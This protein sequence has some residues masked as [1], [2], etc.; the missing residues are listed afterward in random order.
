M[1]L[2]QRNLLVVTELAVSGTQF[3]STS[4]LAQ[5]LFIVTFDKVHTQD[6]TYFQEHCCHKGNLFGNGCAA[7]HVAVLEL[8]WHMFYRFRQELELLHTTQEVAALI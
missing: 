8:H 7:E 6:C 4:M 1:I 5:C 3:I 2:T